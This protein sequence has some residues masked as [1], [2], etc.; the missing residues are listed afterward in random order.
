MFTGLSAFPLTPF[1]GE[2]IDEK[3]FGGIIRRLA[4]AQ[5]DSI[6]V[7]GSTGSYMYLDREERR[8]AVEL[9]SAHAG[10][11]PV[12]AGIGA[13]RTRDVLA[14]AEDAQAAGASGVLLAPVSY[15]PLTE[16]E[17]FSLY[18]QVSRELSVPLCVYDNP[19][20][21]KFTFT[22]EL[23][24]R[25]A[26]LPNVGSIK[27]P[28]VPD[29]PAKA[30]QRI[31]RLRSQIPGHVTIGV[32]GDRFAAAGINAGCDGWYSVLGGLFPRTCREIVQ[33]ASSGRYPEAAALS[34]RLEPLWSLF[35]RFGSLRPAAAI[36][37]QLGLMEGPGLPLPLAPLPPSE[38]KEI[39]DLLDSLE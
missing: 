20:T 14:L 5:V 15:Q 36:A 8:R 21:T 39:A 11:T 26:A 3:A 32:S 9:A 12:I 17:T 7:L 28:G 22:D 35:D 13:L 1:R 34:D 6:G 25:I 33:A 24:G 10:S 37:I 4:Q 2:K 30:R 19:R 29:D 38:L 31:Q 27:I 16:D 18:E 23:H